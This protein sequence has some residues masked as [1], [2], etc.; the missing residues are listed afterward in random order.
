MSVV[1]VAT[2]TPKPEAVDAVREAILAAV[3][4]V[5]AE[6]GCELYALHEGDGVFVMVERWESPEALRTHGK[7]EALS[8]LGAALAGKLAAPL[9]VRRLTP[10]PAGEPGKGAL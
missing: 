2:I 3:P 4:Q 9:D 5:H 1:V 7:A 8:T 6:P 10:V